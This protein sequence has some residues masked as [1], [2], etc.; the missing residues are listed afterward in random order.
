MLEWLEIE[1]VPGAV[2]SWVLALDGIPYEGDD[3]DETI[4]A[5]D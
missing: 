4:F 1:P 5:D 2:R 3:W